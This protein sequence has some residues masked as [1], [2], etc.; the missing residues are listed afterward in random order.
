MQKTSFDYEIVIGEDC[1]TDN[2]R[3]ILL[4][5]Q[6]KFSHIFKLILHE[7][8]LGAMQNQKATFQLCKGK[9]IAICEGD[10][11]WTDPNKLQKQ[12]GF[13][14]QN[15]DAAGCFHHTSLV[16]ENGEVIQQIYHPEVSDYVS[17]NQE[18]CLT[19]LKSS[20][21]TCSLVFKRE[22][23]ENVPEILLSNMCDEFLD[24]VIT[25]KGLLYFLDF[26]GACYR[27]HGGGVWSGMSLT[28]SKIIMYKRNQILYKIPVFRKRYGIYLKRRFFS[29]GQQFLFSKSISK[30]IRISY[31]LNILKYLNY[32]R[33][34]TYDFIV[35]FYANL[36][37]IKK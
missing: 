34:E 19:V 23:L 2:T 14:E 31:F 11:Y 29:E 12:V 33:K 28:Q 4:N 8:N 15:E 22:V 10:D 27:F 37:G 17:Y 9:Y 35:K 6:K 3:G 5:Y 13:L 30:N 20:Y 18:K 32:S 25:E 21:A 26:N 7:S 16:D 36:A 24:L 1:S